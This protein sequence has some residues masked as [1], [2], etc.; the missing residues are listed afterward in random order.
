MKKM[1]LLFIV[2]FF[3]IFTIANAEQLIN[4]DWTFNKTNYNYGYGLNNVLMTNDS[5]FTWHIDKGTFKNV[6]TEYNKSGKVIKTYEPDI[7]YYIVDL[8]Y[9][10]NNYIA[11]DRHGTIYKLDKNFNII[12]SISNQEQKNI[13][14]DKSELK[15]SN[16]TIYYI[17]KTNY[18]I[19]SSDYPLEN[20]NYYN[21]ENIDNIESLLELVPFL[22]ATDK[23]YFKYLSTQLNKNEEII[24]TDILKNNNFY[25][26]ASATYND[27][28]IKSSIRLVD[29]ELN[30][31]W[32]DTYT[33]I[34]PLNVLIYK[35]YI[36]VLNITSSYNNYSI[37]V[38]NKDYKFIKEE[39]IKLSDENAIPISLIADNQSILIKSILYNAE[40][41]L[42]LDLIEQYPE[43]II[44]K[45]DINI[46]DIRTIVNGEGTIDVQ[47]NA[48]SSDLVK[49]EVITKEGYILD[50]LSIKD[51]NGNSLS[52]SDYVF[53]M[54]N[55]NVTIMAIFVPKNP[56]T[57][58]KIN[59]VI[60][61]V[62]ISFDILFLSL[63]KYKRCKN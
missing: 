2:S 48:I 4:Y 53:K 25:Y 23:M 56:N 45:Y 40:D 21:L 63:Y 15:I 33:D 59:Y 8:I 18:S 12:K 60:P 24:I 44:D 39:Q 47:D 10:D 42:T 37:K 54:P 31:I 55:S 50:K 43:I 17:D 20:Y 29:E 61:I 49:F 16:N 36:F 51:A 57:D 19:F 7:E 3:T 35:D 28:D 34:I 1:I 62:I 9:Y 32:L 13:I 6:I 58:D 30:D 26:I 5:Y 11:I 38:Y 14:N 52:V 27:N 41:I 46:F 22:S